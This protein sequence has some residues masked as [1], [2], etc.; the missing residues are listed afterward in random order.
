MNVL[1]WILMI[2]VV[3]SAWAAATRGFLYEIWMMAATIGALLLAAWEFPVLQ[4]WLPWPP[5][6]EIRGLIAFVII[7]AAI[8]IATAIVGRMARGVVHAVGLGWMDRMLGAGLG[9]VRG[10]ILGA[11]L[12]FLLTVYPIQRQWVAGSELAPAFLAGGWAIEACVPAPLARRFEQGL[13]GQ[14]EPH[15]LSKQDGVRWQ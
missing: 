3:V 14:V 12:V 9:F 13:H 6:L 11:V 10:L 2:I 8:L 5:S 4:A 15:W 7:A 1:D